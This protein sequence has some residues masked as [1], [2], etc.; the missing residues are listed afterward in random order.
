MSQIKH[1]GALEGKVL[2]FGGVYSNL[3]ALRAMHSWAED[4]G[5]GNQNIICT[6]DIVGYCAEPEACL[7]FIKEWGIHTIAGNVELNLGDN[8]EDCGC[9]FTEGSRCD[10]FSKQWYPYA[11]TKVTPDSLAYIA[12]IPEF[13][14]FEYAGKKCIVLHGSINNTSE[15]I[16]ASTDESIK[17]KIIQQAES[18]I[19]IGGHSG[20][21]FAQKIDDKL[22][23]NPGVIGMP[24][25]DGTARVWY[26]VLDSDMESSYSLNALQYDHV[27]ANQKILKNPLPATYAETLLTGLW[28]NMEILP[29]E[30]RTLQGVPL[31]EVKNQIF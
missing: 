24:A 18:D 2:L 29:V 26:A 7:Q 11:Q 9:D 13:I 23:L 16:F 14:S 27:S 30:E 21:P 6:G 31:D 22:W 1:I 12:Q 17:S 15:F 28:D 8:S 10:G 25:N 3:E 4:E 19:I 20:L 5:I